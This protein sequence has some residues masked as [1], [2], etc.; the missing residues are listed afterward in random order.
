L[1]DVFA[2]YWRRKEQKNLTHPCNVIYYPLVASGSFPLLALSLNDTRRH[3]DT[4]IFSL[5]DEMKV[6]CLPFQSTQ[7]K[8]QTLYK[9]HVFSLPICSSF[10]LS[11]VIQ[12]N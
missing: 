2:S 8:V 1:D 7:I 9:A 3:P 11:D 12:A 6:T 10:S 4:P 5:I